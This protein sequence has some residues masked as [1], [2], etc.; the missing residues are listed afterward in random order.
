MKT[1]TIELTDEN[2]DLLVNSLFIASNEYQKEFECIAKKFPSDRHLG[3][4]WGEKSNII[5]DLAMDIKDG[6]YDIIKK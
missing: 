2:L 6:K 4:Y 5:Y 3:F 1:K